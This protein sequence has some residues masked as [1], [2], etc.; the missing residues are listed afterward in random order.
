MGFR[1]SF[2]DAVDLRRVRAPQIS[3]RPMSRGLRRP[4]RWTLLLAVIVLSAVAVG[5]YFLLRNTPLVEVREVKVIGLSGHYDKAARKA[6]V[7]EAMTMTTMNFDPTRIQEA[8]G[9][10]VDVAGV[11]VET[12]FPHAAT[13]YL[14]VRRPVLLARL[15]G[16]TV[17]LSQDGEVITRTT[18]VSGLPRIEASGDVVNNRVT[19]GR[20]LAAARLLG[21]APD[22]L[23]RKVDAIRWGRYGFVVSMDSGPDLYFG[24]AVD[25]KLKWRDAATVLADEQSRGLAYLDLRVPGRPA[26]GGLGAAPST[27][28]GEPVVEA[29]PQEAAAAAEQQTSAPAETQPPVAESAPVQQAPAPAQQVPQAP[30]PA[31][32]GAAPD[33]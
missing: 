31:A 15:N 26:V 1:V 10:F 23:L 2:T 20:G 33:G 27:V 24:N 7:A 17:T 28:T 14:D 32:G 4:S 18:A 5:G 8:A 12:D 13:I 6:V 22:V 25:A 11:T 19:G 9:E 30:A 16:R 29:T 3:L 21:A